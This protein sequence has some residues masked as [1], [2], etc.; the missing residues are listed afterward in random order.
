MNKS[1]KI[2][3]NRLKRTCA[4]CGKEI[5]V[6]IYKDRSYRGGH[7]FG[8]MEIPIR[9]GKYKKVG[10]TILCNEKVDVVDWT[11]EKKEVEYW[12]CSECYWKK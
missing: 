2:I 10:S 8:K 7:Y 4:V 5:K 9:K 3:I 11:G 1:R 12:E 6:N